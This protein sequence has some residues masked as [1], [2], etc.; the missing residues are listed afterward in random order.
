MQ[1]NRVETEGD[2]PVWAFEARTLDYVLRL[3]SSK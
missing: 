2:G 3:S 1:R